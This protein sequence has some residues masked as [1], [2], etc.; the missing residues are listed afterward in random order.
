MEFDDDRKENAIDKANERWNNIHKT[1]DREKIKYDDWLQLFDRAIINCK[2]P[3]IDLGCGSGNDTL[4]LIEKGKT[5]IP[6][7]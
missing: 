6:C 1:Y 5:V 7:D 2:T 4:Y 3:V